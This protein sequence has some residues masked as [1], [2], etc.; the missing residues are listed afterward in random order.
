MRMGW[1]PPGARAPPGA[2]VQRSWSADGAPEPPP[3]LPPWGLTRPKL[4]RTDGRPGGW[5]HTFLPRQSQLDPSFPSLTFNLPFQAHLP[6][7]LD[8]DP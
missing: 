8:L 2:G 7:R 3:A 6:A 5:D 1:V 4:G